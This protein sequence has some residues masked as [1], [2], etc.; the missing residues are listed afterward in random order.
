[1]VDEMVTRKDLIVLNRDRDFMFRRGAGLGGG[2][3]GVAN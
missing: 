2:G 3:G 1:M